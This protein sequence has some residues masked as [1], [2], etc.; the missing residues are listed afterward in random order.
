M[1]SVRHLRNMLASARNLGLDLPDTYRWIW[2]YY[3][4]RLPRATARKASS[5]R[6]SLPN[7]AGSR[8]D[9]VIRNNG[10][11]W[12]V[13][14]EIFG[15][16]AYPMDTGAP[17][18]TILD[19]GGNIG[20]GA[21]WFACNY[22]NAQICS[23]EPIPDNL[24]ILKRNVDLNGAK[25]RI[26][27]AAAGLQDGTTRFSMS[28]DPRQHST[29]ISVLRT[30]KVVDVAV[31]SVPS[32]MSLMGWDRIDLLKIDIEG[33]ERDVLGGRPSWLTQVGTIIGEGHLGVGYTIEACRADL[34]PMG[35]QVELLDTN[36]GAI[37]FLARRSR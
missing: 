13:V 35:F 36:D 10:Y 26:V 20:L 37:V 19:L 24:A 28:E 29:Q 15:N 18:E 31:I 1:F 34:E 2:S 9:L 12:M 5:A 25:V 8:C 22:P 7:V 6:I 21:L 23:V 14:E 3:A 27:E 4:S 11:D 33:A 32:L 16:H 30:D 17:P